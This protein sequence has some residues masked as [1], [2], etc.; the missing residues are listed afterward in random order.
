MAIKEKIKNS[1]RIYSLPANVRQSIPFR[2]IMEDGTVETYPGHFTKTY[3]LED[4][5]FLLA[6]DEKQE[7][8]QDGFRTLLHKIPDDTRFQFTIFSH[9]IDKK[10]IIEGLRAMP[11]QDGLNQYRQEYNKFLLDE[12]EKSDNAVTQDKYMTISINNLNV[13]NAVRQLRTLDKTIGDAITEI[14]R[15]EAPAINAYERLKLLHDIYNQDYRTPLTD[16]MIK[17]GLRSGVS[18]KDMVGPSSFDFSNPLRFMIGDMYA[19]TLTTGTL[20]SEMK[21]DY[22]NRLVQT[23]A[24]MLISVTYEKMS[25]ENATKL[26]RD[27]LRNIDGKIAEIQKKNS[28]DGYFL[29]T[30]KEL[31]D[32]QTAAY[33]LHEDVTQGDEPLFY[34]T[35]SVVVFAH[36][37]EQLQNAV[38][39]VKSASSGSGITLFTLK[40]QQEFAFNQAL[41]LC[42][43]DMTKNTEK[44][45]TSTSA[46]VFIPFA[47]ESLRQKN[48][49]YFGTCYTAK[50]AIIC[51]RTKGQNYNGLIFGGSGSGKSFFVKYCIITSMLRDPD[52]QIFV[53]DPQSEYH[54][55]AQAFHTQASE[56]KLG[57]GT[58]EKLNPLDLDIT[59]TDDGIDPIAAKADYIETLIGIMAQAPNGLSAEASAIL[60]KCVR[61]LYI[62]YADDLRSRGITFDART[63]PTLTQLYQ[64]LKFEGRKDE[65]ANLLANSIS[66]YVIGTYDTFSKSTNVD[67]SKRLVVY[68]TMGLGAGSGKELG[69]FVCTSDIFNRMIANFKKKIY[70]WVFIDE[71]HTL[72]ES[73]R[74]VKFLVRFWKMARKWMGV[75]TGITQ[76]TADL[77]QSVDTGEIVENTSFVVMLKSE[78]GDRLNL[79]QMYHL[80]QQQIRHITD[81]N[82]GNGLF[83]NGQVTLPFVFVFP[84][85]TRLYEIMNTKA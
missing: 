19:Q 76:N 84:K 46:S 23:Q 4:I 26:V 12:L 2:G 10:D 55:L 35:L 53:I 34:M 22:F 61:E 14:T 5:N 9:E 28:Q 13:E 67:T 24:P 59:P 21:P 63:C 83:Y 75:P 41:P 20:P 31:K 66:K 51:D 73:E 6:T 44:L 52:A 77:L 15:K 71:F 74:T 8:I 45:V 56:I 18:V 78:E 42:R 57:A 17:T 82:Y 79:Q 7:V 68:S 29:D 62:Q 33:S 85:G 81:C 27:N 3:K 11:R 54:K 58:R 50:S 60:N 30:P 43:K 80:S 38:N 65:I 64:K 25:R 72:L 70:T 37:L 69:L 49:T 39:S 40:W 36:T 47:S 48:G 1:T 16:E 32:K